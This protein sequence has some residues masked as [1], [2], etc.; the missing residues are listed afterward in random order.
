MKNLYANFFVMLGFVLAFTLKVSAQ[1]MEITGKVTAAEDGSGLP[2]GNV[3]VV[4]TTTGTTTDI[5]GAYKVKAASG[6][7]LEFRF[8]GYTTERRTIETVTTVDVVM[9][10]E[11]KALKEAVV[12]GYGSLSKKDVTGSIGTVTSKDFQAGQ[13]TSPDQ[14]I[15]GKV[16]GVQ[17]TTGGGAPGGGAQVRIRGGAS[18]YASNDPLYVIDGVPVDNGGL[19]GSPNPLSLINP[20]DIETFTVLKDASATAIYGSRASNGVILITTKKGAAGQKLTFN[21]STQNSFGTIVKKV[22]VLS[23]DSIRAIVNRKGNDAQKR[24]LGSANTDW[25]KEVYQNA[26]TTDNNLSATGA[27]GKV[28]IRASLGWLRQQGLVKTDLMNRQTLGINLTPS[29]LEGDL[30]LAISLKGSRSTNEFANTGAIGAAIGYDPTQPVY[31]VDSNGVRSDRFHG[32]KE[33]RAGNGL[34]LLAGRNPVGMLYNRKNESEAYRTINNINIDY[35]LPFFRDLHAKLNLGIDYSH[36]SGAG[37]VDDS[38]ATDYRQ[39]GSRY[40]YKQEKINKVIEFYLNY[41]KEL[42]ALKSRVD[43]MAGTAYQGFRSTN[44]FFQRNTYRPYYSP[45]SVLVDT[46][47][48]DKPPVF[49]F[50]KPENRLASFFGRIIYS[51]NEKLILTLNL[52]ADGSSRFAPNQR[53]GYFPAAALAYNLT[54]E[55]FMKSQNL[56]SQLKLRLGYGQTGQQDIGANY[57]YQSFFGFSTLTAQYQF[58]DQF[59]QMARPSAYDPNVKWETTVT[60]NGGLDFGIL[61]DRITA[62]VDLYYKKTSDLLNVVP[63]PA[64]ANFGTTVLTNIGNVENRGVEVQINTIPV[65]TNDIRWD[66]GFNFTANDN[67]VT[68]L[69]AFKDSLDPGTPVGGISGGTGNT[70]QIY[71][72]GYPVNS[73]F[74]FKQVYDENGKPKEGVF[75]DLNGDG[76]LNQSD[77]YHYRQ[78]APRLFYGIS[79]NLSYKKA[80]IGFV[81]R[82]SQGNYIYNNLESNNGTYQNVLA[83]SS[84]LANAS[85]DVNNTQFNGVGKNSDYRLLSDYYIRDASFIRMDN[86]SFGYDFGEIAKNFSVRATGTIQNVFVVT[87]Y[88]GIDP[89]VT[90][91]I[92]NAIYPRPRTYVLGLS[93]TFK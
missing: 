55:P 72:V 49:P 29:L 58:G 41:S 74:V 23:G 24:L 33:W 21:L 80:F 89:E 85:S 7:T 65:Q 68:K 38:A 15:Q 40:Q 73:F 27:V 44:Y 69:T 48:D 12:I 60:Y 64:G 3:I 50:D 78:P 37:W 36:G 11:V 75:Q 20:N 71:S 19:Q 4:G 59:Y 54:Q 88:S 83:Q 1:D 92:D 31:D 46:L 86:I 14:L 47:P 87:K 81:L 10:E 35:A 66:L 62:S 25:Q 16:A 63:T 56:L 77:L 93:F 26:F 45:D 42:P 53:W 39:R 9:K 67:K 18:L 8:L 57:S 43:V 5:N 22:S 82:G 13:I 61:K 2:G 79:T 90:G 91:G 34:E 30:K 70:V 76:I 52:R 6:S 32:Y 84:S 51:F 17:I 28:P